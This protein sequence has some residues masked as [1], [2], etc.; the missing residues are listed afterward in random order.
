MLKR[1]SNFSLSDNP[2]DKFI[3][4]VQAVEIAKALKFNTQLTHLDFLENEP[5]EEIANQIEVLLTQNRDIAELRQYV[6]DLHIEKTPG[7]PF[8]AVKNMADK[9][10]VAYLKSGQTK[11]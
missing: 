5:F 7:F 6:K 9:T 8:D 10:I 11:E 1:I 4:E 3:S 2:N